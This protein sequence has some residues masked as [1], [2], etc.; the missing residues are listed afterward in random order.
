MPVLKNGELTFDYWPKT[1]G[2]ASVTVLHGTSTTTGGVGRHRHGQNL[3]I[4]D[5]I[6][7]TRDLRRRCLKPMTSS[8][9]TG[10]D[11]PSLLVSFMVC[12][13]WHRHASGVGGD[14]I[15]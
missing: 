8:P 15:I 12:C 2:H 6:L 14:C 3:L 5:N 10:T 7:Y 13:W 9:S 1:D 4:K 11:P